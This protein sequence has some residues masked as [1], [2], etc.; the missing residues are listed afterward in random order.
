MAK[1]LRD[2]QAPDRRIEVAVELVNAMP[3]QGVTSM[4]NMGKGLGI[5]LGIIAA[6]GLPSVHITPVVWKKAMLTAG[7]GQDKGASILHAL[8]LFPNAADYLTRK[9]D[10]GRAEALLIAAY[11]R[12][13]Q[14]ATAA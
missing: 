9:K 7:S 3:D 8:R 6:L 4:F 5:W 1:I 11:L 14:L 13:K 2:L 10:D 12:G